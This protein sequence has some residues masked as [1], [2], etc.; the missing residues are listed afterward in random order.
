MKQLDILESIAEMEAGMQRATDNADAQQPE[1]TSKAYSMLVLFTNERLT[2]FRCEEFRLWCE[3]KL[4]PP[5]HDRAFGGVI[6][7]AARNKIIRQVGFDKTE[8]PKAHRANCAL[9]IKA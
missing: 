9:W 2:P 5:P 7:M 1:W 6:R 4:M 3:G 8:N